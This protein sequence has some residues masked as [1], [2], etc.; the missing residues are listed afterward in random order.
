MRRDETVDEGL[1][2]GRVVPES[3]VKKACF[4]GVGEEVHSS[5]DELDDDEDEDDDEDMGGSWEPRTSSPVL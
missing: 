3:A 1:S 5:D 4:E 2:R